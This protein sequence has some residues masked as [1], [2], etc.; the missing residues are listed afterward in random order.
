MKKYPLARLL[1]LREHREKR[2]Q[3]E[4][5]KRR[6]LVEDARKKAEEAERVAK[7]F[8]E[9]RPAEEAA[10]FDKIRNQVLERARLDRYHEEIAALAARELELF[11]LAEQ[12]RAKVIAAEK[13]LAEAVEAHREALREV[14]KFEEHRAI[15]WQAE[16]KRREDIQ[17]LEAE[18]TAGLAASRRGKS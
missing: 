1:A 15:W 16:Q 13:A 7:E 8:A 5:V 2:A 3:A 6:R 10:L 4:V 17:E 11:D 14:S 12:E 9:R 18:E